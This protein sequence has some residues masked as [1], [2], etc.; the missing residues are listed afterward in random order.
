MSA[1]EG[2]EIVVPFPSE[3]TWTFRTR[4]RHR[5]FP[6]HFFIQKYKERSTWTFKLKSAVTQLPPLWQTQSAIIEPF[7]NY[8]SSKVYG[9]KCVSVAA[10]TGRK[11]PT[12]SKRNIIENLYM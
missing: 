7:S 8:R 12:Y 3:P 5:N 9:Q 11:V 10:R 6:S 1:D 4:S 2:N